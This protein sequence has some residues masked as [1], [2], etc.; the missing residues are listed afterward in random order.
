MARAYPDNGYPVNYW[1][2]YYWPI[3][4]AV[5]ATKRYK[6]LSAIKAALQNSTGIQYV[7]EKTE[8]WWDWSHN[9]YP[10]VCM[11]LG[12]E[13]DSFLAYSGT[14]ELLDMQSKG[15]IDI[16]GYVF[17]K[18]NNLGDKRSGLIRDI[19]LSVAT[20]STV[21]SLVNDIGI[22]SIDTDKGELE[23]FSVVNCKVEFN[24]NYNRSKG[25]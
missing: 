11:V 13:Q 24:Y 23:N 22:T 8:A 21:T 15:E 19:E 1:P 18:H 9:K 16:L 2:Q 14:T 20:D 6:I 4:G 3:T 25:E 5:I 17:D 10:G 7:T 12:D